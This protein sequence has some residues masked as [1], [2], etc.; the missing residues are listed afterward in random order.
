[1]ASNGHPSDPAQTFRD[2][3]CDWLNDKLILSQKGLVRHLS[4]ILDEDGHQPNPA[5]MNQ[6][7]QDRGIPIS[8]QYAITLKGK[9]IRKEYLI[10]FVS[11]L[12]KLKKR[13]PKQRGAQGQSR[14]EERPPC[15]EATKTT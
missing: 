2:A 7:L 14:S 15:I 10:E 4:R 11:Q 13:L 9:E 6:M 12:S 5:R 3:A 1:M 8:L